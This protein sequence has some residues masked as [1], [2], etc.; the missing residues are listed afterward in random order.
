MS[1]LVF[2]PNMNFNSPSGSIFRKQNRNNG[3]LTTKMA[4][5]SKFYPSSFDSLLSNSRQAYIK[6]AG[7]LNGTTNIADSSSRTQRLRLQAIGKSS[8]KQ[9]LSANAELSFKNV[10]LQTV[11]DARRKCR[12]GG[13][14]APPKKSAY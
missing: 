7:N 14:T 1:S 6:D 5:P 8:T 12:N 4:M 11:K 13:C 3:L 9:G 2:F 10:S